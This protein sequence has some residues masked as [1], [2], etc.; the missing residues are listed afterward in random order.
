MVIILVEIIIIS[1][2]AAITPIILFSIIIISI[3]VSIILWI[4]VL[5]IKSEKGVLEFEGEIR[6]DFM[7]VQMRYKSWGAKHKGG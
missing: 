6:G 4:A 7:S 1:T 5:I 3:S 2:T